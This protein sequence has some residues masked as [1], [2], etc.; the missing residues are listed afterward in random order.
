MSKLLPNNPCWC[1][2]GKKYK[3]CHKNSDLKLEVF[4]K[5][6]YKIPHYSTLKTAADIETLKEGGKITHAILD[7]VN[8]LIKPGISTEEIN[9]WCHEYTIKNE[10]VPAPLNYNG[11]PKSVCTSI[12][13]VV[14]HGIPSKDDILK[15][16]DI[17]NVDVTT[18]YKGFHSDSSRM[19]LVGNVSDEA[20]KIVDV[21]KEC[22]YKGLEQVKP[23]TRLNNVG[24]AIEEYANSQ[25]CSVVRDLCGH[26]IGK[27]FHEEP[28]VVHYAQRSKGTLLIPGMVFT[29]EPMINLGTWKVKTLKDNWTVVTADQKLSAQ[30]EHTIVVTE[31]G[32][33]ILT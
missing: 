30:W 33:E 28:E 31:T 7:G 3:K 25:G 6:G 26:G 27:L 17:V 2:S 32:Y 8:D 11:F 20:Q 21:A 12:N 1:G 4:A 29:I 9:T 19:Y 23:Y 5:E 24:D 14:C 15:E 10:G 13:N 16:G 22:L 18:I